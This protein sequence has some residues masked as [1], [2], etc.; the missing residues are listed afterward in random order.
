VGLIAQ[1]YCRST[2]RIEP[3]KISK[4]ATIQAC[5]ML[6]SIISQNSKKISQSILK[7]VRNATV[8]S[9]DQQKGRFTDA[10]DRIFHKDGKNAK[11]RHTGDTQPNT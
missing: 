7:A 2:T 6:G 4:G 1:A 11:D 9:F 5:A 10:I 8:H 3:R